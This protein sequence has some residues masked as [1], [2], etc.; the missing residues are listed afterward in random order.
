MEVCGSAGPKLKGSRAPGRPVVERPGNWLSRYVVASFFGPPPKVPCPLFQQRAAAVGV[1][2]CEA[3]ERIKHTHLIGGAATGKHPKCTGRRA[4]SAHGRGGRSAAATPARG[5]CRRAPG[6][7][8]AA[9]RARSNGRCLDC[10]RCWVRRWS[11]SCGVRRY[12][13]SA[14]GSTTRRF[15]VRPRARPGVPLDCAAWAAALPAWREVEA[16]MCESARR[17]GRGPVRDRADGAPA[18][19]AAL[20]RRRVGR[21][22]A[23]ARSCSS[24]RG[25]TSVRCR[26]WRCAARRDRRAVALRRRGGNW[27]EVARRCGCSVRTAQGAGD[28]WRA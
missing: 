24:P 6:S 15:K 4:A 2:A 7:T 26:G 1:H 13:G 14:P 18:V 20:R 27:S 12:L 10:G 25:R 3:R 5:G 21:V 11:A 23:R 28:V 8:A 19:S 9:R 22:R 17:Y 16:Q